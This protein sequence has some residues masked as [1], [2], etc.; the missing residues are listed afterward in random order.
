MYLKVSLQCLQYNLMELLRCW[1]V[2][3]KYQKNLY[4]KNAFGQCLLLALASNAHGRQGGVLGIWPAPV[5][6]AS[7]LPM[8]LLVEKI[9]ILYFLDGGGFLVVFSTRED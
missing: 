9:K 7:R 2:R 4:L 6:I 3:K 5:S 8:E 1:S